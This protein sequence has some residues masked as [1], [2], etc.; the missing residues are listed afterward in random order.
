MRRSLKIGSGLLGM[1]LLGTAVAQAADT[2]WYDAI[3]ASGYGQASYVGNLENSPNNPGNQGRQFDTN[4]NSFNFNTF[5]LQ[6]AKPVGDDH[7]GFTTRLRM[8]QDAQIVSPG[9]AAFWVQE[10][11]LTYVLPNL[12]KLSLIGGK[13]TTPEGFEVVDTVS[14]P[15]FSEGLLF[16]YAEPI[17]H[18]GLKANYVFSDMVN[19]TLGV[20]NGWDSAPDNN[21]A[22]T[23]LWQVATVPLKGAAWT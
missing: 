5:L 10:A 16:T 6:I 19:A 2:K 4:G 17:T 23:L 9:G 11:Y 18:T 1:A 13:F 12:T 21:I 7:F 15:N 14:N 8:G 22:K 20:V 3:T